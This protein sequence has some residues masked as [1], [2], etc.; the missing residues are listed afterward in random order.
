MEKKSDG[1]QEKFVIFPRLEKLAQALFSLVSFNPE[2][3][4]K[5]DHEDRGASAQI[6]KILYDEP[7]KWDL[8]SDVDRQL[9]NNKDWDVIRTTRDTE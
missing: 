7:L 2:H 5:S 9:H 6:D 1:F 4:Y 3:G 8:Q